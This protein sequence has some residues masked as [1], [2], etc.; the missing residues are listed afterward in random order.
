VNP[1]GHIG[2]SALSVEDIVGYLSKK[3]VDFCDAR[4]E[5]RYSLA[6]GVVNG[7]LRYINVDSYEGVSIRVLIN[8]VWGYASTTDFS[9]DSLKRAAD[10]AYICAKK[11]AGSSRRK[12]SLDA[13]LINTNVKATIKINPMDVDIEEK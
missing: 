6:I 8:G 4:L 12:L 13:T 9:W 11:L 3:D 7:E 10:R 5:R 2:E 1:L